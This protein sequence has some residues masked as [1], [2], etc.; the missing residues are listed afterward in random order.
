MD[1]LKLFFGK[2]VSI[3]K[4][5]A[6]ERAFNVVAG[7]VPKALPIVQSIAAMTPNKTD[8]EIAAAFATYGVPMTAQ[9][10]GTPAPQRG[11]LLLH[12]A[13]EVLAKE[14]P[15]LAT[16]LL[17]SAAQIAFTGIKAS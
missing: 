15:G 3:F 5:G 14:F 6:A 7:L 17:N 10:Q 8:D 16:N 9:V 2:V 13:T 12:L 11:Y 4:S 1:K